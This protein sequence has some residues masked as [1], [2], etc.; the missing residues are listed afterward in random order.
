LKVFCGGEPR[1]LEH[2]NYPEDM[3]VTWSPDTC[4]RAEVTVSVGRQPDEVRPLEPRAAE[5]L[6]DLL[7]QA[8]ERQGNRVGWKFP[9]GVKAIFE[10]TETPP[11]CLFRS[12]AGLAPPGQLPKP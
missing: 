8:D 4:S 5:T 9:G 12:A 6:P 10:V 7:R 11:G 1:M 2:R 3:H